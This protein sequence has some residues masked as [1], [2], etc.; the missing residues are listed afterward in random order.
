[1]SKDPRSDSDTPVDGDFASYVERLSKTATLTSTKEQAQ[2]QERASTAWPSNATPP[3][4]AKSSASSIDPSNLTPEE[5]ISTAGLADKIRS[6][7]LIF[8]LA[9]GGQVLLLLFFQKG[10]LA[11]LF[12]TGVLWLLLGRA[13]SALFSALFN[14]NSDDNSLN[15]QRLREQLQHTIRERTTKQKK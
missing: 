13:Q 1:M 3:K 9:F 12:F 6:V 15:L 10:S 2:A 8:L 5:A 4:T 14:A 7:R 11:L